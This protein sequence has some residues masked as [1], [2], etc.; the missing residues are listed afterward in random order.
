MTKCPRNFIAVACEVAIPFFGRSQQG[1]YFP[2]HTWLFRNDCFHNANELSVGHFSLRNP[3]VFC[4]RGFS[5]KNV[6]LW[7]YLLT[8]LDLAGR[9]GSFCRC[10]CFVFFGVCCSGFK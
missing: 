4:E 6:F 3:F 9:L 10:C 1:S 5:K 7:Y 8:P 2:C